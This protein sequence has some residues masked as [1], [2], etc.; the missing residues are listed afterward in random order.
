MRTR[1]KRIEFHLSDQEFVWLNRRIVKS[2]LTL[3]AYIRHLINDRVPQDKP[4]I[5]YEGILKELRAIGRNINQIAFVANATGIIG[6]ERYERDY[7]E[8]LQLIL[9]L[10]K[11]VEMPKDVR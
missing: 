2:G 4:P 11:A 5:E 6:A 3:S 10:M 9:S 7:R 8:I 1:Q